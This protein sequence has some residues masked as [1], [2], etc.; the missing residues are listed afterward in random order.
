MVEFLEQFCVFFVRN[1]T[2]KCTIKIKYN[3]ILHPQKHLRM[4]PSQFTNSKE[5]VKVAVHKKST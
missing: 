2:F 3:N 5:F 4:F 1:I